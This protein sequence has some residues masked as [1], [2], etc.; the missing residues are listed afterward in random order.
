M[1]MKNCQGVL[2]IGRPI[3]SPNVDID[4]LLIFNNVAFDFSHLRVNHEGTSKFQKCC[5]KIGNIIVKKLII[6]LERSKS[7]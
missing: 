3:S 7:G 5:E 6:R 2:S 1:V 4:F